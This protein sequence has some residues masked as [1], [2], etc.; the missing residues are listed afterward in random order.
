MQKINSIKAGYRITCVSWENDGDHYRTL[1]RDGI[2]KRETELIAEIAGSM[3]KRKSGLEN[4]YEASERDLNKGHKF[5]LKIFEKYQDFFDEHDMGI[6]RQDHYGIVEYICDNITGLSVE[7]YALR[8]LKSI[9]I[10]Y[11]PEEIQLQDVTDQ[12]IS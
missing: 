2:S 7:G 11:V 5:F 12:F 3:I 6:F 1:I 10:E 9:C 4:N 8:V